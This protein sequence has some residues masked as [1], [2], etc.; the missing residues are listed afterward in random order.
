MRECEKVD[1]QNRIVTFHDDTHTDGKGPEYGG[2]VCSDS[3]AYRQVVLTVGA[4]LAGGFKR[5]GSGN[6]V[7]RSSVKKVMLVITAREFISEKRKVG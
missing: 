6:V 7:S 1:N 3:F 5:S 2:R 4:D